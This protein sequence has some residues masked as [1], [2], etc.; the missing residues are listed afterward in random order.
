MMEYNLAKELPKNQDQLAW[1]YNGIDC[2]ITHE[3]LTELSAQL[4]AAPASV[5]D[6]Y[7]FALAKQAPIMEMELRGIAVS[8]FKRDRVFAS[9]SPMRFE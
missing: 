3:V 6:T 4:T 1:F 5:N 8:P 7:R 2:F 9:L